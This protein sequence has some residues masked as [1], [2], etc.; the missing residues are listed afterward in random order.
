[1][2]FSQENII[3]ERKKKQQRATQSHHLRRCFMWWLSW[4]LWKLRTA[5][6]LHIIVMKVLKR[7]MESLGK[8][9]RSSAIMRTCLGADKWH[10]NYF[11]A[12]PLPPLATLST[13]FSIS[14]TLHST[15]SVML[16]WIAILRRGSRLSRS[17]RQSPACQ[18][19]ERWEEEKN[20][21]LNAQKEAHREW[22]RCQACL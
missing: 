3:H 2:K 7:L 16:A 14:F 6:A 10:L 15:T 8:D 13:V 20:V 21:K 17:S 12:E 11:T 5:Y 19:R 22:H 1:M 9:T 4:R 18:R